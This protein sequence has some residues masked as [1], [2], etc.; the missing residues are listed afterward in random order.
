VDTLAEQESIREQ[1]PFY[2]R[3]LPYY[4]R[5]L[6][7]ALA[8]SLDRSLPATGDDVKTLLGAGQV[9]LLPGSERR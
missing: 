2:V 4:Q 9:S 7:A 6:A 8:S 1:L 3:S 5:L